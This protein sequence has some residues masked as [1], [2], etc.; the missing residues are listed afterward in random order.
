MT[1]RDNHEALRGRVRALETELSEARYRLEQL[2][3]P[4]APPSR[5]RHSSL[6]RHQRRLKAHKSN[7]RSITRK[8]ISPKAKRPLW[9]TLMLHTSVGGAICALPWLAIPTAARTPHQLIGM[10]FMC[11]VIALTTG[12]SSQA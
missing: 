3:T 2:R 8:A 7:Y 6:K 11:A 9:Q 1:Y 4:S 12:L 10:T 5:P